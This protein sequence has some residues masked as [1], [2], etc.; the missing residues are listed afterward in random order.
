[1]AA[2]SP[3]SQHWLCPLCRRPIL[4]LDEHCKSYHPVLWR[5]ASRRAQRKVQRFAHLLSCGERHGGGFRKLSASIST[6]VRGTRTPGTATTAECSSRSTRGRASAAECDRILLARVNSYYGLGLS[7][8]A[9]ATVGANGAH[10]RRADFASFGEY[11]D[12]RLQ[13]WACVPD[14]SPDWSASLPALREQAE[15]E[16]ERHALADPHAWERANREALG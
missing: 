16:I 2:W 6:R 10:P 3:S 14:M 11:E 15:V 8:G 1:M 4:G 7:T 9:T 12:A 13:W 5:Y